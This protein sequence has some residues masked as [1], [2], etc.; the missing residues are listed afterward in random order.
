LIRKPETLRLD[1][2]GATRLT[3]CCALNFSADSPAAL[4]PLAALTLGLEVV[5]IETKRK[6]KSSVRHRPEGCRNPVRSGES[7][8]STAGFASTGHLGYHVF[9]NSTSQI[10]TIVPRKPGTAQCCTPR[11]N[12]NAPQA[13]VPGNR[14]RRCRRQTSSEVRLAVHNVC[15]ALPQTISTA[16]CTS[17]TRPTGSSKHAKARQSKHS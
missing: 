7:N 15:I 9:P 13:A 3:A 8:M 1:L 4:A 6:A 12:T 2:E 10:C 16:N 5:Q 17:M 11:P 14:H